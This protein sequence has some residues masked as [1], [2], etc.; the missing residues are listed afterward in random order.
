MANVFGTLLHSKNKQEG[1]TSRTQHYNVYYTASY[2]LH[3]CR[4]LCVAVRNVS[5]SFVV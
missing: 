4:K 1:K 5:R 3:A 2:V